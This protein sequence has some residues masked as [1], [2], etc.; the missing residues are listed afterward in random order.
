MHKLFF[1]VIFLL[2]AI[3]VSVSAH[4]ETSFGTRADQVVININSI[5]EPTLSHSKNSF[6]TVNS[7]G[8]DVLNTESNWVVA[9]FLKNITPGMTVLDVGTGYGTLTR[10]ALSKQ[11]TVVSNDLSMQ[12]LLYH[13]TKDN[14]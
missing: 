14:Q 5:P 3:A 13:L 2:L 4:S 10:S 6:V 11:A 7:F 12:Q 9:D 1:R 8:F